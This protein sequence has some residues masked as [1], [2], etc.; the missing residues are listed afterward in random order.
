MTTFIYLHGFASSPSSSKGRWLS[1]RLA[2][3][4]AALR[5]PDL[6]VPDFAHL[7]VTAMIE[8]VR[9]EVAASPPGPIQLIGSSLGGLVATHFCARYRQ[10]DAA[11]VAA[12]ALLAPALDFVSNRQ[13]TMGAATIAAWRR[14]GWHD[15]YNYR[16]QAVRPVHY[17]L[18]EDATQY[19]SAAVALD[20]PLLIV[21]GLHDESV[22]HE[23]SVRFAAGRPNVRL[24]LVDSDHGMLEYLP[25]L[26]HTLWQFW[27]PDA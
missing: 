10:S 11:T 23:Q 6:N 26:W 25:P 15:F 27:A 4:G 14:S 2:E 13:Q 20:L 8:R 12:L 5:I 7:T 19:D 1:E 17:G 24:E 18:L 22:S 21:H 3:R 16:D 9:Q